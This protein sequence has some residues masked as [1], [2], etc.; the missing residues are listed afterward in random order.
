LE[1]IRNDVVLQKKNV[2][3]ISTGVN[4]YFKLIG[5]SHC[6]SRDDVALMRLIKMKVYDPYQGPK[7]NFHKMVKE[8]IT[9]NNA[10]YMRV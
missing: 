2:K 9:D 4:N 3:F 8:W 5:P 6:C 10:G 7:I 1:Q